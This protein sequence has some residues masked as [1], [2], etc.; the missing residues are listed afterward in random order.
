[1]HLNHLH[2]KAPDLESADRFYRDY[3][4]FKTA[5]EHEG[6]SFLIDDGG[7]LLAI[8]QYKPGEKRFTY[9]EWYH[10][11]FCLTDESAVRELYA[12]MRAD[13]VE[14]ARPLKEYDDG[15]VNFYCLDPAG[16]KVEV[17]WNPEEA[18][19]FR[20]KTAASASR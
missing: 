2:I 19:L 20:P 4:G 17:S 5:F 11:G 13:G 12:R 10:F 1:M 15:T 16:H 3:F 18:K 14:F 8:F 7:F 6:A 9:P